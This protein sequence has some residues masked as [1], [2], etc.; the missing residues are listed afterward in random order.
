MPKQPPRSALVDQLMPNASEEEKAEAAHYWFEYL[1]V[2]A[3][4]VERRH[5]ER[6]QGRD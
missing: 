2:L 6:E 5:R 4:I 1:A 3:D